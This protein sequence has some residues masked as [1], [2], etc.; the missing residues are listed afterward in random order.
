MTWIEMR[1]LDIE[2]W[3]NFAVISS[4]HSFRHHALSPAVCL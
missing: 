1:C 4:R 3:W 2:G